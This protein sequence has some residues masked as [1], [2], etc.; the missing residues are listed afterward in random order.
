MHRLQSGH[1]DLYLRWRHRTYASH[2][3]RTS[4]EE[5]G[6]EYASYKPRAENA[7]PEGGHA[8]LVS[9]YQPLTEGTNTG[10]AEEESSGTFIPVAGGCPST[11]DP[12]YK[13]I[14]HHHGKRNEG[15][16]PRGS[17]GRGCGRRG[18]GSVEWGPLEEVVG[19]GQCIYEDGDC[20]DFGA[21]P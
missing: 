1:Y 12:C 6:Y 17:R 4:E 19:V 15:D 18:G 8:E 14:H 11:H 3:T 13:H 20:P 5:G 9:L 7:T 2:N 21:G 10:D 16:C